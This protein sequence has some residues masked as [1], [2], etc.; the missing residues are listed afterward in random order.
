MMTSSM[1]QTKPLQAVTW[2]PPPQRK[3][4]SIDRKPWSQ[5]RTN[6]YGWKETIECDVTSSEKCQKMCL[7]RKIINDEGV[8]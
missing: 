7:F 3:T 2:T 1:Q 6:I 5:H 4:G 8:L